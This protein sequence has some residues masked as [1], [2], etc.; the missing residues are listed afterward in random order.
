MII[1]KKI[2]PETLQ[3]RELQIKIFDFLIAIQPQVEYRKDD[4]AFRIH[5][6]STGSKLKFEFLNFELPNF[7]LQS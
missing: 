4:N 1:T 7:E 3:R 5:S 2:R 6:L